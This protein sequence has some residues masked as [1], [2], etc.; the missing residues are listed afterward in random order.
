MVLALWH[1][2]EAVVVINIGGG[3]NRQSGGHSSLILSLLRC[4][5][6]GDFSSRR[7]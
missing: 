4:F 5:C 7:K 2:T 6:E 3:D 1:T